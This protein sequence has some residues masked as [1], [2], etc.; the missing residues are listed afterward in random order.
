MNTPGGICRRSPVRHRSEFDLNLYG[1]GNRSTPPLQERK[2]G[3]LAAVL[4][5]DGKGAESL[6]GEDE[7]EHDKLLR[8]KLRNDPP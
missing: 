5:G 4:R 1:A 2:R 3:V 7:K 8:F 6:Y